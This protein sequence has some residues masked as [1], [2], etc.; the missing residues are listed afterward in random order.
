MKKISPMRRALR[1]AQRAAGARA[2]FFWSATGP[3]TFQPP[4]VGAGIKALRRAKRTD[5]IPSFRA[6]IAKAEAQHCKFHV[7]G[8]DC[9]W[10]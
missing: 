8:L 3:R 5:L 6:R 2:D 1:A 7:C 9:C 4:D 10:L